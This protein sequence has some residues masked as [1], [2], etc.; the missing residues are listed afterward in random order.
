MH[1]Y[2]LNKKLVIQNSSTSTWISVTPLSKAGQRLS[3]RS[4]VASRQYHSLNQSYNGSSKPSSLK[5][6][7]EHHHH[8]ACAD[9]LGPRLSKT[10]TS[11]LPPTFV[12]IVKNAHNWVGENI[13][14]ATMASGDRAAQWFVCSV[15]QPSE[16]GGSHEHKSSRACS[17]SWPRGRPNR[18]TPPPSSPPL[19]SSV[20]PAT[21]AAQR[22]DKRA[23]LGCSS[24]SPIKLSSWWWHAYNTPILVHLKTE[25]KLLQLSWVISTSRIV[26]IESNYIY[27]N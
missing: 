26:I 27:I 14:V 25:S 15:P 4:S 18:P 12:D 8:L 21:Q 13:F 10:T 19:S 23:I 16:A 17:R 5:Q 7:P 3:T 20:S 2:L 9:G 11:S 1:P 24:S 22:V 6:S